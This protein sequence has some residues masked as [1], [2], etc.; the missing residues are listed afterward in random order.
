VTRVAAASIS[1]GPMVLVVP[2]AVACRG[3]LPVG[4]SPVTGKLAAGK[5]A[6]GKLAAGKLAV[7]SWQCARRNKL[8]LCP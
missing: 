7:G 2:R 6:A 4:P 1:D 8:G 5:L 3:P